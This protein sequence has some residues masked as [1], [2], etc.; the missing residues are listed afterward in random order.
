MTVEIICH[1]TPSPAVWES[2]IDEIGYAHEIAHVNFRSK[3]NGWGS[4]IDINFVDKEHMFN[5]TY[6]NLY[7]KL[8]VRGLSERP[9]CSSCKFKFPNGQ[10]DLTMGDPWGIKTFAPEMYD[11]RGVSLVFIHTQK[12]KTFF[13]QSKLTRQQVLFYDAV[14]NNHRFISSTLAD[15]RR[16][17]FFNEL[18]K[19]SDWFT[20]MQ[21]Y[22]SQEDAEIIKDTNKRNGALFIKSLREILLPIRQHFE[23][24]VLIVPF[25]RDKDEQKNL[26]NYFEKNLKNFGLYFLEPKEDGQLVC[27]E[28]FSGVKFV[29]KNH[30]ELSD[31]VKKYNLTEIFVEGSPVLEGNISL[32][33]E[34]LKTCNL[35]IKFFS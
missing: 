26:V 34:W 28:N 19:S 23:Q 29:F 14:R 31:F 5:S 7:G 1:G 13:E 35:P 30:N 33:A 4:D 8:F 21:K 10:S 12:G 22:Y 25:V 16:E 11:R 15:S 2:Y 18:A 32:I 24:K 17:N 6:N 3:R 27:T 9:S 20:V